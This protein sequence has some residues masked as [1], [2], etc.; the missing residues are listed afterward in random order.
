MQEVE[1]DN[2]QCSLFTNYTTDKYYASKLKVELKLKSC[3]TMEYMMVIEDVV[4]NKILFEY[5]E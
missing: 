5:K 3:H 1:L 2:Y 4:R